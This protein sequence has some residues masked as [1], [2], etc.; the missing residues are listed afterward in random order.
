MF[1]TISTIRVC[2]KSVSLLFIRALKILEGCKKVSPEPSLHHAKQASL[3]QVFFTTEV[4][5]SSDHLRGPLLYLL[6]QLCIFIVLEASDL[7]TVLQMVCRGQNREQSPLLI[8]W[9]PPL[10][11]MQITILLA[12]WEN[13]AIG[14]IYFLFLVEIF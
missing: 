12:F 7:D 10:L 1:K 11:L 4:L 3:Y 9:Q 14:A 5:Q 13:F 8:H 2:K 6:Q